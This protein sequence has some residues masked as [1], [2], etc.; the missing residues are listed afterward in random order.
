MKPEINSFSHEGIL[1]EYI[2]FGSGDKPMFAFHGFSNSAEMFRVLEPSLGKKFT[3][4]SF[5]LPYHGESIVDKETALHGIDTL[6]LQK[7]FKNFLWH[8]HHTYF[9]LL[10]YS[11][12]GKLALKL[13][14]LFPDEV[15]SVLLFAPDGIKLSYWYRFV[16][17]SMPGKWIYK[18]LMLHPARYMR[19][20]NVFENLRLVN[21]QTAVFVRNSLDTHGKREMVYKTWMCMR[22]LDPDTRKIKNII[23]EKNLDFHL[24]FGKYDKVILPSIGKKFAR[25]L[26]NKKSLHILD[27]GH[28][29]VKE[30]INHELENIFSA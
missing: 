13:I 8:I 20:V 29:L 12:G 25:G 6:Q 30:K 21:P 16:T 5:N 17:G 14:E 22:N 2:T 7:Y 10:G 28:Q 1:L 27:A 19:I 23:N 15:R 26:R 3:I 11:I 4:Y 24:F 18:R 9:S